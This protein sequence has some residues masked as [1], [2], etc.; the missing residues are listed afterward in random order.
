MNDFL[1]FGSAVATNYGVTFI[2][3][4][5][6]N[7]HEKPQFYVTSSQPARFQLRTSLE[8]NGTLNLP[9]SLLVAWKT[10]HL[11]QKII[12]VKLVC[13]PNRV[14]VEEFNIFYAIQENV[15]KFNIML[16]SESNSRGQNL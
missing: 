7:F 15:R 2:F 9:V 13:F 14:K 16:N 5:N 8:I 6:L 12:S 11:P 4:T 10:P 1:S 3:Q